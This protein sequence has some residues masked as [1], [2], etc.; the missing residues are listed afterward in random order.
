[1]LKELDRNED[2]K[3]ERKMLDR[4]HCIV[5]GTGS[6][7]VCHI[8]S[9]SLNSKE[10]YRHKFRKYLGPAIFCIFS[11]TPK[12]VDGP[13]DTSLDSNLSKDLDEDE[14]MEVDIT[15]REPPSTLWWGQ[16]FFAF[17]PL[18]IDGKF[19]VKATSPKG[20]V[21]TYTQIKLQFHWMP[22][23]NDL[24]LEIS[25][26]SP[27]EL[28][29]TVGKTYGDLDLTDDLN[30]VFAQARPSSVSHHIQAGDIFHAK[31]ELRYADLIKRGP[32]A[33]LSTALNREP[34]MDKAGPTEVPGTP[35]RTTAPVEERNGRGKRLWKG[36]TLKRL[37]SQRVVS[38]VKTVSKGFKGSMLSLRD[39]L[40]KDR[41]RAE[42]ASVEDLTSGGGRLT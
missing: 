35:P 21:K 40:E 25:G 37:G 22:R 14:E 10:E 9:F 19:Q 20:Q 5:L 4:D 29:S 18:G 24:P 1:M 32:A 13:P 38:G 12:W 36:S 8:V 27:Q 34:S 33:K 39:F 28:S 15:G 23:R 7:K 31:V 26:M 41:V 30:P 17:K 42:D 2:A 6:P 16:G 3:A 11:E